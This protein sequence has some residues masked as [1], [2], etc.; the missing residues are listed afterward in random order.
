MFF[1]SYLISQLESGATQHI[2]CQANQTQV[3]CVC[4]LWWTGSLPSLFYVCSVLSSGNG[5]GNTY[6]NTY[7]TKA[8]AEEHALLSF[9]V[10]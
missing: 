5:N 1:V 7:S 8:A 3:G 10:D 9:Y 6:R 2:H 4:A